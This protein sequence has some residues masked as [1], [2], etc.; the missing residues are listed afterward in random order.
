[1]KSGEESHETALG[2]GLFSWQHKV[3]SPMSCFVAENRMSGFAS[4]SCHRNW[5]AQE[6]LD[7]HT[8]VHGG[9]VGERDYVQHSEADGG[10]P[11][12]RERHLRSLHPVQIPP[13]LKQKQADA[14]GVCILKN[15]WTSTAVV[16]TASEFISFQ[17]LVALEFVVACD[18]QE[19]TQRRRI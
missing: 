18:S 9:K 1:M 11:G 13:S 12:F 7:Q 8:G 16:V 15:R 4:R 5:Q 17:V 2:N 14:M 10:R 6:S 3:L 19:V